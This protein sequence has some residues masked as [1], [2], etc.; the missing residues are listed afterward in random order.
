MEFTIDTNKN[1]WTDDLKFSSEDEK[2]T[3]FNNL[4]YLGYTVLKSSQFTIDSNS[5]FRPLTADLNHIK[6]T[7]DDLKEEVIEETSST[8]EQ[9]VNLNN[10]ILKLTGNIS[11][12]S[13]KGKIGEN[14]VENIL[15]NHFPDDTVKQTAMTGHESDFHLISSEYPNILIESKIYTNIVNSNE[16]E[17]FFKDLETTG[18]EYGVFI[19]LTSGIIKHK[20]FD[21]EFSRGKHVIFIPNAGFDGHNLIYAIL[22]LRELSKISKENLINE[23]LFKNKKNMI[24][25]ILQNFDLTYTQLIKLKTK[26]MEFKNIVDKQLLSLTTEIIESE[27]IIKNI[28]ETTKKSILDTMSLDNCCEDYISKNNHNY[29]EFITD[30]SKQKNTK[31]LATHVK[32][33]QDYSFT[34]NQ[35]EK[36]HIFFEKKDIIIDLKVMKS[37]CIFE[38]KNLNIKYEI[39]E[40]TD[41]SKFKNL[42]DL[43]H[44]NC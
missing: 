30:L 41:L 11:T 16:I 5:L 39:T 20:R 24:N 10:A 38:F 2:N 15:T 8:K 13:L 6:D 9:C 17:K 21:Y 18:I 42:I 36:N 7:I 33:L 32:L 35:N 14:F 27:L 34:M 28:I 29:D 26:S 31:N 1:N 40:N 37:K 22:F 4:L 23:S 43:I 3:Y 44:V 19:S 25:T 12:S